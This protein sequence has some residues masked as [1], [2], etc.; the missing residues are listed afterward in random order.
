[1]GVQNQVRDQV[2]GCQLKTFSVIKMKHLVL[3]SLKNCQR[4]TKLKKV[5]AVLMKMSGLKRLKRNKRSTKRNPKRRR[6]R[7]P[8][9]NINVENIH[10][11]VTPTQIEPKNSSKYSGLKPLLTTLNSREKM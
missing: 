2:Q 11:L 1:M 8:R 5:Q 7:S 6:K 9:K 3:P 4:I 10:P